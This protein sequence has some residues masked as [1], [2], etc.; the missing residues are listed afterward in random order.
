MSERSAGID[1]VLF[2]ASGMVGQGVQR[3][4]LLDARVR[5]VVSIVRQP[6]GTHDAKLREIVH[7]DFT[8]FQA[9]EGQLSEPDACF[10]CLGVSSSGMNEA[11]YSR[12]SYDYTLAA[13]SMLSRRNPG[14][15]FIYVSGAGTDATERGSSMWARVKGKTENALLRLPFRAAYMFRPGI[16]QPL[17]GIRSKTRL[18]RVLYAVMAPVLPVIKALLPNQVTTTEQMGRAMIRVAIDGYPTSVLEARD[19]SRL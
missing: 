13:A 3:E 17:H 6:T 10:Y 1:V 5:S 8:D 9:L 19:I 7:V 14:M 4:C 2:G 12:V 11:E 18:Y 15:V 16:I